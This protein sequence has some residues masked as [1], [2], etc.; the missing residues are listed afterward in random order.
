[1][2]AANYSSG[3]ISSLLQ[4]DEYLLAVLPFEDYQKLVCT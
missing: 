3:M 2:Q 1:M 4:V